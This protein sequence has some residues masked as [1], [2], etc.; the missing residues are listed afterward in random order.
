MTIVQDLERLVQLRR[1]GELSTSE[2]VRAKQVLL[3]EQSRS[4]LC[5]VRKQSATSIFG[6]PLWAVARGPDPEHGEA[7]GHARAIFAFGD[8]A[9]GFFACGASARG[10][11]AIGGFAVGVI[12]V[13]GAAIGLFLAIGGA[14]VGAIALGGG[15][16]G[17]YACGG[18][19]LGVHA[20]TGPQGDPAGLDFF[21]R[22]FGLPL[23][24]VLANG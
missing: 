14:A 3:F 7:Q 10:I 6:I 20:V 2:F 17:Y 13:G 5:C 11:I 8:I 21:H 9:T 19:A 12:A 18:G 1:Q 23:A 24:T 4:A 15:A 22:Y 16:V